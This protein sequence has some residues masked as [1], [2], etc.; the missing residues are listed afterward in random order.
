MA[1][2]LEQ[3]NKEYNSSILISIEVLDKI[4]SG[5]IP[6]EFLGSVNVKGRT[7]PMGVYKL[8]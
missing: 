3:L 5:E 7:E 2:R 4:S 1:A 8:A 6:S